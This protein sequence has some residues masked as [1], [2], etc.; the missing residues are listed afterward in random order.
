MSVLLKKGDT[1]MV[2]TGSEKGKT[3]K[4]LKVL[5]QENRVLI[6]KLNLVKKH[7][8]PSQKNPQGGIREM[9]API[10]LSNVM[11]Y[12][13]KAGKP[14]RLGIKLLKDGRKAR[15]SRKSGEVIDK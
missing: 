8:K 5:K 13:A 12:D 2:I 7:S 14:T 15:V 9:E 3:G 11:Y 4:I 6:E 10:N 1:V